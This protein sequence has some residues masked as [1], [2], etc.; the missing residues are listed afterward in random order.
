LGLD[1]E[2]ESPWNRFLGRPDVSVGHSGY[3]KK[4]RVH[5]QDPQRA[6]M[7]LSAADDNGR[8]MLDDMLDTFRG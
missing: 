4:L 7:L 5:A 8:R 1:L 2:P 3:D 6:S